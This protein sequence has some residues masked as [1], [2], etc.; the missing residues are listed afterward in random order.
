[1]G[2]LSNKVILIEWVYT[3]VSK[4]STYL[5]TIIRILYRLYFRE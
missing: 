4:F 2:R 3:L 1:M 5:Q